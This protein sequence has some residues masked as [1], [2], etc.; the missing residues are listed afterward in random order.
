MKTLVA[1]RGCEAYELAEVQTA[2]SD[3]LQQ[4]GGLA[5]FISKGDRVLVKPNLL[6]P[7]TPGEAVT[8]HPVVIRA[9]VRLLKQEGATVLIGDSPGGPFNTPL[10]KLLY[11]RCGLLEV[12]REEGVALNFNTETM[13]VTTD[14]GKLVRRPTLTAM[15]QDV[16]K[17][18]SVAKFKSHQLTVL[19][20]CVKNLF[21]LVPGILKMEYHLKMPQVKDFADA[22][23]DISLAVKPVLSIMDG[24]VGMEG[25]GPSGGVPRQIGVILASTCPYR[26][27]VVMAR[28][29]GVEPSLVPTIASCI[30]RGLCLGDLRDIELRGDGLERFVQPDFRLTELSGQIRKKRTL[31]GRLLQRLMSRLLRAEP[32]FFAQNCTRCGI[33]ARSCPSQAIVIGRHVPLVSLNKCIRCFCCQELC[34][35]RSVEVHRPLLMRF[36]ARL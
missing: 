12:A 29:A 28:I 34:P 32:R 23:V 36:L 2:L 27:D 4:L 10:L 33:C 7:K 35:S 13:E 22:L 5:S 19:T 6:M 16:D 20:G 14:A 15:L 26:L 18:I 8:T 9:L 31:T 30:A 25:E 11:K 24:I 21:G 3:S 17:V 1:I